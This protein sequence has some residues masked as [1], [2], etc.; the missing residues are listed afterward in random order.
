MPPWRCWFCNEGWICERCRADNVVDCTN[1]Q[2]QAPRPSHC[3]W[4]A[5]AA[6]GQLAAEAQRNAY[7]VEGWAVGRRNSEHV[8]FAHGWM[9]VGGERRDDTPHHHVVDGG[10]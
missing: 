6:L 4:N 5:Q 7:Y 1:S 3:W 8:M 9:E 2:C 10:Y